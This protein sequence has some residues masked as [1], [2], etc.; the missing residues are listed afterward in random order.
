LL[1][2]AEEELMS[3]KSL[4][5]TY[6][7]NSERLGENL[8][9]S[10]HSVDELKQQTEELVSIKD[11]YETQNQQ[12]KE[13][14]SQIE[15]QLK[16]VMQTN[17]KYENQLSELETTSESLEKELEK[18]RKSYEEAKSLSKTLLQAT[19][20]LEDLG[21]DMVKTEQKTEENVGMM[22]SLL[23][24]FKTERSEELFNQLDKDGNKILSY[25]EFVDILLKEKESEESEQSE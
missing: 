1:T 4:A 11:K 20:V 22:S 10:E 3:L 5:E 24:F 17:K 21:E 15:E 9:K 13:T 23:N 18:T 8:Q 14:S 19:G 25:D 12:L 7:E 16:I 2:K 6:K